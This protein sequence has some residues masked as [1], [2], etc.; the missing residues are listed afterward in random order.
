MHDSTTDPHPQIPAPTPTTGLQL[1]VPVHSAPGIE[2]DELH[3]LPS[4]SAPVYICCIDYCPEQFA[5]EHVAVEHL[6]DFVERHRPPWSVVRWINVDGLTNMSV[7]WALAH[8]YELHPLAIEDLLR[9]GQRPKVDPYHADGNLKARLFVIMKMVQLKGEH[10]T[11]EQISMFVGHNTVLTFQEDQ[12]DVWDPIREQIS[13][14][15]SRLRKNDASFLVYALLDATVDHCFPILEFY[16]DRIEDLEDR[17]ME[18]PT[19]Q[20]VHDIHRLKRELLLLRR[21]VWPMRE[22]IHKLQ[23]ET[24]ECFSETAQTYFRDVYDHIVQIIDVI[25]AY[26][27]SAMSLTETYMNVVSNRMNQI[28]KVLTIIGTIF[29]PL[30]FL[31]G[32]YG[33]NFHYMPELET[34]WAYPAFWVIC[35]VLVV[36]MLAWFRKRKWL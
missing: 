8:K 36:S 15:G 10:V 24:H 25:E 1:D 33:M 28:M 6:K 13:K 31:A 20:T 34:R 29:I 12:G 3:S 16:G 11:T 23:Q 30:T 17:I 22:L 26:R 2:L 14:T 32:V 7:I 35:L 27:E 19:E 4:S 21:A 5:V 18:Q 9:L